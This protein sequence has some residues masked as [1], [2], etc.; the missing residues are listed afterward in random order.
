MG[1]ARWKVRSS[2]RKQ[3]QH[4][5]WA[6]LAQVGGLGCDR[7]SVGVANTPSVGGGVDVEPH[8]SDARAII[9]GVLE[10]HVGHLRGNSR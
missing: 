7:A 9:P 1:A 5:G 10:C 8:H 6:G 2:L 3:E 4:R